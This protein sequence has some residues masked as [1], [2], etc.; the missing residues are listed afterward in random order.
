MAWKKL[1]NKDSNESIDREWNESLG[2][3]LKS[4]VADE[5]TRPQA[6]FLLFHH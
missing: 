1:I 3:S 6:T 2:I 4:D 5:A